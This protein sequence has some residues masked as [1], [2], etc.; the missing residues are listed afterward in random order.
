MTETIEGVERPTQRT[1]GYALLVASGI[2]LSRIAGL[3]RERAIAHYFGNS[4]ALGAFRAAF[5]IPNFLQNLFGEGV[6]SAA[7]IPVYARLLAEGRR[8][9]ADRV[10]GVVASLLAV[11]VAVLVLGGVL[12]APLLVDLLAAGFEGEVRDLTIRLVRILFPGTGLLVMYAWCLGILNSHRK[13]FV[14]YVAP[15]LWNAAMIVA[16][17]LFGSRQEEPRLAITLAWGAVAGSALQLGIQIP[18]VI[19]VG[20]GIRFAIALLEPVRQVLRSFVPVLV[21][22]GVV[23]LSAFI[24]EIIAS[25]L[26]TAAMAA[27]GY[28]QILYLLPISLFGMSVAAAELPQMASAVG[29]SDEIHAA[30]RERIE[31]ALRQVAFFVVPSVVAFLLI[32]DVLVA[33]LFQTGEF[34]REDTLFVWYILLGYAIGLLAATLGRLYSSAFYSLNDTRTPLRFA[35]VRVAV[36]ATLGSLF[37]FPLRPWILEGLGSLGLRTPNLP[38]A[39]IAMGAVGLSLA[40]GIGNWI[41]FALLRRALAQ[42]I[43]PAGLGPAFQFKIWGSALVAGALSILAATW[44][45]QPHPIVAAM[46]IVGLFG[47]VY[48]G[49]TA[50]LG[51]Q[52][53]RRVLNIIRRKR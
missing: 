1:G 6:L 24:D 8:D 27:L 19:R 16:L 46:M 3:V 31:R 21:S 51:V 11:L 34:G 23:Q 32:G 39:T 7:F 9:L 44:F 36:G 35:I 49:A 43:G 4:P 28:A 5:R 37:A 45:Q 50:A 33:A 38:G 30:V 2:F 25:F 52:E 53:T 22:R 42:R 15:V 20:G 48:V 29:T 10:A 26:G 14:G 40:A 13:F 41:E 47:L 18:F 17:V 12:F